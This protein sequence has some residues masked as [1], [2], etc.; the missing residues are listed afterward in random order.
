MN[1]RA[2][3][4]ALAPVTALLVVLISAGGCVDL[5]TSPDP[6]AAGPTANS[7]QPLPVLVGDKKGIGTE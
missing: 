2:I 4:R 3:L 1:A 5:P 6:E 7:E